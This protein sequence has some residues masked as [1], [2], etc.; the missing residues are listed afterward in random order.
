MGDYLYSVIS[1]FLNLYIHRQNKNIF[2][3]VVK[4]IIYTKADY[5]KV[6]LRFFIVTKTAK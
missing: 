2:G 3:I 1:F 4:H 6:V 5:A